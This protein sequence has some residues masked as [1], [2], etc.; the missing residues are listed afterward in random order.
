MSKVR[1][2]PSGFDSFH[3]SVK[4]KTHMRGG[5]LCTNNYVGR[6]YTMYLNPDE[7]ICIRM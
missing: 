6:Y 4:K 1:K 2:R 7:V 3:A 5:R